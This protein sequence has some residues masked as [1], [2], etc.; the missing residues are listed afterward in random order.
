MTYIVNHHKEIVRFQADTPCQ[1]FVAGYY[2]VQPGRNEPV[3]VYATFG[4]RLVV[5]HNIKL[6]RIPG[7]SAL[8]RLPDALKTQMATKGLHGE[9]PDQDAEKPVKRLSL[10]IERDIDIVSF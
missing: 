4:A 7:Q 9:T 1:A 5:Y 6:E 2:A 3:L 10:K 8:H